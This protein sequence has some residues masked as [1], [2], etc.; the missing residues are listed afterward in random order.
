MQIETMPQNTADERA[1]RWKT[2]VEEHVRFENAHDLEGI[3]STFGRAAFYDDA[4]WN[5]R[6]TGLE[7]VCGYYADLIRAAPD[8]HI[9][10]EHMH[11]GADALVLEVRITGT[12]TGMWR[13]L[14][15]TGRRVDFPLC[16]IY[17]FD[18]DDRLAGERIY[19]DRA[20]VLRQLGVFFEPTTAVGRLLTPLCHPVTMLSA[21]RRS[22]A[23]KR[24]PRA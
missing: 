10:V 12:H 7:E 13:G 3:M 18:A 6:R 9:H 21:L 8:L 11:V 5:D 15:G 23:R 24:A 14:P 2:L 1:A 4:P 19:Y 20:T 22:V 17:T 16:G